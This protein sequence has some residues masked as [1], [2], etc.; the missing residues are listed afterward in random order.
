MS[1]M[2]DLANLCDF[3]DLELAVL[4]DDDSRPRPRPPF[5]TNALPGTRAKREIMALRHAFNQQLH[6][7]KDARIG[8]GSRKSHK[9]PLSTDGGRVKKRGHRKR[10]TA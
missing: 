3:T 5:P 1:K 6:H 7:P 10:K 2:S 4:S 9:A 8:D